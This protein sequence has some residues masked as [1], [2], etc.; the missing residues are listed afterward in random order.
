MANPTLLTMPMCVNADKNTIPSTDAGTSGAFSEE[1]GWQNI[2]S[3]PLASGGKAPNRRDF[4]GVF[5][6][7]GGI[8][9]ACQR[10]FTFEWDEDQDYVVGCV[11][12]DT[13][14]GKRYEC[15]SDVTANS[16][17]PN[18]DT[19]HW[20]IYNDTSAML[21][22]EV[23]PAFNTRDIITTSGTYT[24]PVTG[25]YHFHL[26]GGGGAGMTEATWSDQGTSFGGGGGGAGGEKDVVVKLS[27]G[28]N[29]GCIVGAGGLGA[30]RYV[31]GEDGGTTS[32]TIGS[33][34]YSV[35][36]GK[37]GGTCSGLSAG[38]STHVN[39]G[40]GYI[41]MV[42][43]AGGWDGSDPLTR[44]QAGGSGSR[45]M[46]TTLNPSAGAGGGRGGGLQ[47]QTSNYVSV[48]ETIMDATGFGG[49][50]GG[51][52]VSNATSRG[53]NGYQGCIIVEYFATA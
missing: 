41:S 45:L 27:A 12:I 51:N 1:Y 44:G 19:T 40:Y 30:V 33:N 52:S 14:D 15:I 50:G 9:Y 20:Q 10:G 28:D 2:N 7:L 8:A 17:P 48:S 11:V 31:I 37:A 49:G 25:W 3:L 18:A 43:G 46:S 21:T 26:I 32:I 6:L 34:T 22:R 53:G 39:S 24:A 47:H 16:T 4:N 35:T 23:T 5:A 38:D 29:V 42:G 13:N 36:G